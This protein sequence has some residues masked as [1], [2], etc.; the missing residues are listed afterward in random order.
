LLVHRGFLSASPQ[1]LVCP[2]VCPNRPDDG[3]SSSDE[4]Q[5]L[6]FRLSEMEEKCRKIAF[7]EEPPASHVRRFG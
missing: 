7:I 1:A 2:K 4:L 3:P 5:S 6:Q